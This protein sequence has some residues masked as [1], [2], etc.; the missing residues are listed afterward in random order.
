MICI[1][2]CEIPLGDRDF[3]EIAKSVVVLHNST[4]S[5]RRVTS[6]KKASCFLG[7]IEISKDFMRQSMRI[8]HP[9]NTFHYPEKLEIKPFLSRCLST[10]GNFFWKILDVTI[11]ITSKRCYIN[12]IRWNHCG[13]INEL[14]NIRG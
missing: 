6:V 2:E 13:Y 4:G 8:Y 10:P 3:L 14:F 1:A 7:T 11:D 9:E 5:Y 12:T